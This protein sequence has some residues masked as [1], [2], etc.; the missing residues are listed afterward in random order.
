MPKFQTKVFQLYLDSTMASKNGQKSALLNDNARSDNYTNNNT[1]DIPTD[2]YNLVYFTC[3]LLGISNLSPYFF[4]VSAVDYYNSKYTD[5]Q[6]EEIIFLMGAVY[7]TPNI[8]F[9]ILTLACGHKFS[10]RTRILFSLSLSGVVMFFPVFTADK[11]FEVKYGIASVIILSAAAIIGVTTATLQPPVAGFCNY[12]PVKYIRSSIT[13]QAIAGMF[14][15]LIRILVNLLSIDQ[16][17]GIILYFGICGVMVLITIPLFKFA[18]A[19]EFVQYHLSDYQAIRRDFT[20]KS[21]TK[22]DQD[23]IQTNNAEAIPT[24]KAIDFEQIM[25]QTKSQSKHI[26]Q[27]RKVN[28]YC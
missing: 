21:A 1:V 5:D 12:L 24:L 7:T 27:K 17:H 18:E 26:M 20:Q 11:L 4:L 25:T 13:G 19:T 22:I 16:D 8:L 15:S 9:L 23:L 2:K 6:A 3:M 28:R 14:A 10:F